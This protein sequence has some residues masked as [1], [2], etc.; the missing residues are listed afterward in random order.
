MERASMEL[1][2]VMYEPSI[3]PGLVV[4]LGNGVAGLVF[5]SGR[6]VLAGNK[7]V[8]DVERNAE[9]VYRI[10]SRFFYE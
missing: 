7:S 4:R 10:L 1:E 2:N 3:F 9:N 5:Y 8:E 6:V